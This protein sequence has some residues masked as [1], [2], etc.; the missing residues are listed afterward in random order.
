MI[1][2]AILILLFFYPFALW[3][4]E[5]TDK[6]NKLENKLKGAYT[7]SGILTVKMPGENEESV[8]AIAF[9]EEFIFYADGFFSDK[10]GWGDGRWY[11][12]NNGNNGEFVIEYDK[13]EVTERLRKKGTLCDVNFLKVNGR[14]K[15]LSIDKSQIGSYIYGSILCYLNIHYL[16]KSYLVILSGQFAGY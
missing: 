6:T 13:N 9:K 2:K 8:D 12:K 5:L 1:K 14:V 4:Y 16:G 15:K 7:V 3:A 10:K 11:Y